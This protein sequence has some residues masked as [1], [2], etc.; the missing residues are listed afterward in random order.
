[1][2]VQA[3]R[4][5]VGEGD[6]GG[7]G[8]SEQR[9]ERQGVEPGRAWRGRAVLFA[10]ATEGGITKAVLAAERDGGQPA[11]VEVIEALSDVGGREPSPCGRPDARGAKCGVHAAT[12]T[13]PAPLG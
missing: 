5:A 6:L 3:Q 2:G 8:R 1:M 7:P 13:A 4:A 11:A 9:T 10:P 12:V